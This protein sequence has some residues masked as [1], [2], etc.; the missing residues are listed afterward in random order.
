MSWM[1]T[2]GAA[3]GG[4]GVAVGAGRGVEVAGGGA[5]GVAGGRRVQV[6]VGA[7]GFG[8]E[9]GAAAN[10]RSG[11]ATLVDVGAG[12]LGVD[13]GAMVNTGAGTAVL[14]GTGSGVLVAVGARVGAEVKL[15][16]STLGVAVASCRAGA[17]W[18]GS[19]GLMASVAVGR[20]GS[21]GPAA[22]AARRTAA[23][24]PGSRAGSGDRGLTGAIL[25]PTVISVNGRVARR[26]AEFSRSSLAGQLLAIGGTRLVQACGR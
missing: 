8:V 18:A 15:G 19:V 17:A 14:V 22:Q 10:A 26:G 5:V 4:I 7:R 6:G 12:S 3:G 25:R 9:V 11:A 20:A 1:M 2:L 13:V 21:G 23:R 16:S 24:S